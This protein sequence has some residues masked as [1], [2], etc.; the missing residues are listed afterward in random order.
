MLTIVSVLYITVHIIS[1]TTQH[2]IRLFK[3]HVIP[4][5][6]IDPHKETDKCSL[7]A[8]F[9]HSLV[10]TNV[11]QSHVIL[12]ILIFLFLVAAFQA[13]LFVLHDSAIALHS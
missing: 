13:L 6:V 12:L 5:F 4:S 2:S 9:L 8:F 3:F 7:R 10:F 1:P 11:S